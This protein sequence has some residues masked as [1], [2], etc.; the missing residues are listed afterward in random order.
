[1]TPEQATIEALRRW[2]HV[3]LWISI[4]LPALGALA[5]GARDYVERYEKQLSGRIN[6]AA[7]DQAKSE[8]ATVHSELSELKVKT[9]PRQLKAE[10]R[11]AM[12]PTVSQLK[13][14]PVAFAC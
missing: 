9:A 8:A 14:R 2:S 7:I 3:L 4:I 5:A 6:A 13:G 11:Q 10:Q 1:M 12:L